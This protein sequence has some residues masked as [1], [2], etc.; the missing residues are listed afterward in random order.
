DGDREDS[1]K[2][3]EPGLDPQLAVLRPFAEQ[4]GAADA[5]R[6]AVVPAR[7]RGIDQ[8]RAGDRHGD[9]PGCSTD[10]ITARGP[11]QVCAAC[12]C[13]LLS[14]LASPCWLPLL[15][16]LTP[17]SAK[18]IEVPLRDSDG[19]PVTGYS[20]VEALATTV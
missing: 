16:S 14:L 13:C 12:P 17:G 20:G 5:A 10:G 19:Q 3:L 4:E 11:R 7:D 8:M 9:S 15:A 2:F 6:H 18:L 1:R